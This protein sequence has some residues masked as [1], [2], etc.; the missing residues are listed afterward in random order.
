MYTTPITLVYNFAQKKLYENIFG[1]IG[2]AEMEDIIQ[3]TWM[4]N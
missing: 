2:I 4:E 3:N 1:K